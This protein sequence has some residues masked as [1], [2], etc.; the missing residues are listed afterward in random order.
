MRAPTYRATPAELAAIALLVLIGL[1]AVYLA[2][3][4]RTGG[5]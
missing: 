3:A 5:L 1:V 2:L 4:V